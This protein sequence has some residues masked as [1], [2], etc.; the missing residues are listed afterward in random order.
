MSAADF[1]AAVKVQAIA[2]GTLR[3]LHAAIKARLSEV[4]A[5]L[6]L[7]ET[8]TGNRAPIIG[9]GWL[10]PKM[11]PPAPA[12]S[13]PPNPPATPS[14]AEQ[15]PFVLVRPRTGVDSVQG[16]DQNATAV[17][18]LLIGAYHD[19]DDGW[20]DVL[21][22]IQAIRQSLAESPTLAGTPFEQTGPLSWELVAEQPR[23]QWFG[24]VT[25]SW[26]IPRP[27]RVEAPA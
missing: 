12:Q 4:V 15:F 14:A 26:T 16:G 2:P 6:W 19:T 8:R 20:L 27:R 11:A 24:T 5:P 9:D 1:A 7:L 22:V 21:D 3:A 10:A 25:T 18:E 13:T 23:P 17:V